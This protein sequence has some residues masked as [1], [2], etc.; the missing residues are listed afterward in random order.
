MCQAVVDRELALTAMPF[1]GAVTTAAP[2]LR[3]ARRQLVD[4]LLHPLAVVEK[5]VVCA[6]LA[7]KNVH[8]M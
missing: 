8:A 5:S 6:E 3:H 4:Q 2:D 1:E 7:G